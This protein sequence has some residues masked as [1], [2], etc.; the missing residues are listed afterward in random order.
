M[1]NVEACRRG[2]ARPYPLAYLVV[3]CDKGELHCLVRQGMSYRLFTH[4][5]RCGPF[6]EVG[7]TPSTSVAEPPELIRIKCANTFHKGNTG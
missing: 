4:T 1:V 6:L 5:G 7:R 2:M 3:G